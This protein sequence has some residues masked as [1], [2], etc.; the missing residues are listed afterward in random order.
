MG[1]SRSQAKRFYDRLGRGQDLQAFYEDPA[2]SDLVAH[3]SFE[4]AHSVFELG[5]GTGRLADKLLDHSL[6]ADA[7]YLGVDISDTMVNLS[8]ARLQR[9]GSRAQVVRVDGSAP[10][11]GADATFDRIVCVYVF[12]L[13]DPTDSVAM[14]DEA[15]RLLGPNGCLCA[16]SLAPGRTRPTRLVSS[17]WTTIWSRVPAVVGGCRPIDLQQLLHGWHIEY[18]AQISAWGLTSDIVIAGARLP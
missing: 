13:L 18:G 16:V 10:L 5:C 7:V 2:V 8:R 17:T 14:L 6:P 4:T 3:S 9:F 12:D 1:L 11:P 15:H